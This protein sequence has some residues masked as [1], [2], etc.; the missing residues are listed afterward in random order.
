MS[1]DTTNIHSPW[2]HTFASNTC[3]YVLRPCLIWWLSAA[4]FWMLTFPAFHFVN[5]LNLRLSI[6]LR[7][8]S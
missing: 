6:Y 1:L 4:L 3:F 2:I 7:H 8:T 5:S